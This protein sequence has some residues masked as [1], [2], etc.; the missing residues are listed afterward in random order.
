MVRAIGIAVL[1]LGIVAVPHAAA[2]STNWLPLQLIGYNRDVI[3]DL[4]QTVRF[5]QLFDQSCCAWFESG[6]IDDDGM[7]H[8]DGIPAGSSFQSMSGSGVTYLI[9]PAI[10]NNV[11]QVSNAADAQATGIQASGT[12]TLVNPKPYSQIAIFASSGDSTSTSVGTLTVNYEDGSTQSGT[13]NAF[14]WCGGNNLMSVI[15]ANPVANLGV[16]SIGRVGSGV[17]VAGSTRFSYDENALNQC[18]PQGYEA[19]ETIIQTDNTKNIV[20]VTFTAPTDSTD[21]AN[22]FGISALP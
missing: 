11:L 16:S 10:Y 18:G 6:A 17:T 20:S 12:L 22:V 13:W 7:E 4:N 21:R 5:V 15:P 3:A 2:Q 1:A 9:Q 19:Y 14:D 8:D